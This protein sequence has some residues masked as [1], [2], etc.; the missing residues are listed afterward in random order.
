M[1]SYRTGLKE[2]WT[3]S[4]DG[5]VTTRLALGRTIIGGN[6]VGNVSSEAPLHFHPHRGFEMDYLLF[7]KIL[8]GPKVWAALR[9]SPPRPAYLRAELCFACPPPASDELRAGSCPGRRMG[10]LAGTEHRWLV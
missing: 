8:K 2:S 7:T 1:S 5:K 4:P 9:A 6:L 10:P 3:V